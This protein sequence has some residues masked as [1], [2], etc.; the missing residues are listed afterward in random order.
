MDLK[1]DVNDVHEEIRR[2]IAEA[3]KSGRMVRARPQADRI[4]LAAPQRAMPAEA[5]A[6]EIIKAGI[7]GGVLLEMSKRARG[8]S[9]LWKAP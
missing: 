9:A 7:N 2:V 6:E 5:I 3:I 1:R 8:G 4:A